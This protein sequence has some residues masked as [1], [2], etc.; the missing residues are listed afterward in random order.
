VVAVALGVVVGAPPVAVVTLAGVAVAAV[1]LA[2]VGK[3]C[4]N[5]SII[6]LDY[7]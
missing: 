7:E 1:V 5:Q 3:I 4:L 2:T 6:Y